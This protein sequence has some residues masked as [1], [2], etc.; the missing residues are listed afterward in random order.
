M[1]ESDGR[2]QAYQA[3]SGGDNAAGMPP[4]APPVGM[5]AGVAVSRPQPVDLAV[6]LLWVKVVL[7]VVGALAVLLERES[8]R[9]IMAKSD[10]SP[11]DLDTAL[12]VAVAGSL[13]IGLI[14]AILWGVCAVFVGQGAQWARILTTV[15]A[16]LGLVGT[17]FSFAQDS[18][19][20]SRI[21]TLVSAVISLALLVLLW[22][23]E[24]SAYFKAL[25]F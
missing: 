24:S 23:K 15:F 21:L 4:A 5:P 25:R 14:G 3:Y 17:L 8:L 20:L 1:S 6:K 10:L 19:S 2:N 22:R 7:A 18:T 11:S 16:V 13:F 9:R 12:N